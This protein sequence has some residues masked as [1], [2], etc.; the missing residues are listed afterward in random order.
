MCYSLEASVIAGIALTAVGI[1]TVRK[2]AAY[3]RPMIVFACFPFVFATH[4]LIEAIVWRSIDR[5][6]DGD[7]AFR[8][9]YTLIAFLVWPALTP[10]AAAVAETDASRR[11]FWMLLCACGIGLA[12]HLSVRLAG[13]DGIELSVVDHSIRYDVLFETPPLYVDLAYLALTV[14]PLLASEKQAL[15]IFGAAVF[16]TFVYSVVAK[17]PAWFSVWCMSAAVFSVF[18]AFAIRDAHAS[19]APHREEPEAA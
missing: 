14:I 8:Y 19:S 3:D 18:I 17:R 16:A 12:L 7:V 4:Q 6:F 9:A 11:R 5:P 10:F 1:G 15:K 2:A 13:A